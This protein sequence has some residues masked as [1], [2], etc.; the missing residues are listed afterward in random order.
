MYPDE[1]SARV[2]GWWGWEGEGSLNSFEGE[3]FREQVRRIEGESSGADG[4][5]RRAQELGLPVYRSLAELPPC[6]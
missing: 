4:D 5:V 3:L 1:I 2:P 6:A